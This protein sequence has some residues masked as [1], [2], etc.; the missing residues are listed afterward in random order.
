M[1]DAVHLWEHLFLDVPDVHA[2]IKTRRRK[3]HQ[4]PW[5]TSKLSEIRRDWDYHHKKARKSNSKYHWGMYRKLRNL[6]NRENKRLKSE[7]FCNLINDSKGD[8]AKMWKSLK[9]VIPD[10]K[11]T[12]K[13]VQAL[14]VKHKV[15]TK[16]SDIVE[17]FN[18]HF[19]TIGQKLGQCFGRNVDVD[20][21]PLK[22]EANFSLNPVSEN[23][24][25]D[26]LRQLKP[27]KATGLDKVSSR[28]LKDS[29]DVIAPV[30]TNIINC[31]FRNKSFPQSWKSA[32]VMALFK[33]SDADNC[34]NYRPISVLPTVSKIVERAAHIQLYNHLDSNGLLHVKQFGFRRK[35]STSSALL[36]FSDDILQNME[37]GLVTGVVFLDLKKAFDTVNHRVLLLKLRAL[38]V[39]DSAVAWLK[40]YL[41]NRC[42]RTVMGSTVST[43]RLVN[44]GVPQ[45][46]VLGPLFF[47][48][49]LMTWPTH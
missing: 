23:F 14:K 31:S 42:Q 46:S 48:F 41:T 10:S 32:K 5:V 12:V 29:A 11:S 39:D 30:L 22:T 33:N 40:I 34:D 38:G 37:D 43:P 17:I 45:G 16:P 3:G 2:P 36:Q 28:L 7:Y 49:I 27:N 35:R 24:V 15:F 21:F 44:I 4:T 18:K 47:L 1:N 26:Q 6:A 13:E 9:Q 8:S 20:R 25:R 19:S